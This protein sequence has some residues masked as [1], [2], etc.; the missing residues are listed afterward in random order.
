MERWL[1]WSKAHDWKSCELLKVPRVQIPL[2][3]PKL[4]PCKPVKSVVTRFFY[5]L[6]NTAK[7]TTN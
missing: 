2:S 3:P 5:T 4:K 6:K 7:I 1:S